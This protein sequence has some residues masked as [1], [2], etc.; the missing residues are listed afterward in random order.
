MNRTRIYIVAYSYKEF[1]TFIEF[2]RSPTIE[3]VY[4]NDSE[5]LCGI[6]NPLVIRIGNYS[7]I[8]NY[9]ELESYIL[10]RYME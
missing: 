1:Q 8:K 9:N 7:L 5:R 10:S 6:T 2:N 3:F 4:I